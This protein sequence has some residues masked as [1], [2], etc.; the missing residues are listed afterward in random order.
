VF[1]KNRVCIVC[2]R[3]DE[4]RDSIKKRKRRTGSNTELH[5]PKRYRDMELAGGREKKKQK[6]GVLA[7]PKKRE[8]K[9]KK[10]GRGNSLTPLPKQNNSRCS[11]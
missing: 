5:V 7:E 1:K 4:K 3:E 8:E 9:K 11:T 10:K 2:V 6:N